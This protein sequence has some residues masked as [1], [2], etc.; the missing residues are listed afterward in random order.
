VTGA[1]DGIAA[2]STSG[3]V[4][5]VLTGGADVT[6]NSSNGILAQSAGNRTI[7]IG[8]GSVVTGVTSINTG[9]AGTTLITNAGTLNNGSGLAIFAVATTDGAVTVNN[10]AG[11]T[12]NGRVLL[13]DNADSVTNAGI[14]N[15]S[16]GNAFNGGVDAVNNQAGG[17]LNTANG[18]TF[19]GLETL[20]NAGTLNTT[21]T[22]AF[23]GVATALNNTGTINLGAASAVTGLGATTNSLR[24]NAAAGSSMAG[25]GA[26][27]NAAGGTIDTAGAFTLGGFTSFSNAGTIDLAPGAFTVPAVAFNNS[28]TIIADEGASSITGQTTFNNSGTIRMTDG[29]PDDVLT[30]NS[31]FVGSGGSNLNVDASPSAADRLVITG[32]AS[33]TTTLNV[34]VLNGVSINSSGVLVVDAGTSTA[35]AFVL[36]STTGSTLIDLS[37][38]QQGADYFLFALPNANAFDP[39]AIVN[40]GTD[41]WYQSADIYDNYAALKRSDL[42]PGAQPF[43]VWGQ[44]YYDRDRY[45]DSD[46][47]T[48]FGGDFTIN[49]RLRTSRRGIQ[50]GADYNF[51]GGVIGITGGWQ[52]VKSDLSGS[53]AEVR[54]TGWNV[55]G[56]A[57]FGSATGLYGGLLVK[58]DRNRLRLDSPAFAG[59]GRL[60]G[61]SLGAEAEGG[62]RLPV[63]SSVI[64]IG[65][66]LA[67]VTTKYKDFAFGGIGYDFD[68]AKSLRG[69][70][71]A[72]VETDTGIFVDGKVFHEFRDHNTL[73]LVSGAEIDDLEAEGRGTWFR[74]E[75]G[76]GRPHSSGPIAALW[77]ELGDVKGFGAKLGFRFGGARVAEVAPPPPPPPPP[78]PA[79][80]PATQ[81]CPDGSVILAT[82]ACPV[83]PPPPPPPAPA[84]ERGH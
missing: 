6:G 65:A 19:G 49:Q 74:G 25:T 28:G 7:N 10:L 24:I 62:Y 82:D 13:T 69:R 9:G 72:R 68:R 18:T 84:P 4:S 8:T 3:P 31:N 39:L 30:I 1:T 23:T 21:G 63:G 14:W 61:R 32:A 44:I 79:P 78:P 56:Y 54:G 42:M 22:L 20:S 29:A 17:V 15:A 43:G 48:L 2:V 40:V 47:Q 26:F 35:N 60:T 52:K 73:T 45:G 34:N 57:M 11:G 59:L 51:G 71:G 81:T 50:A 27:N 80:P 5:V 64:D 55:G 83:P 75:V 16:G 46:T 70:F 41:M 36:G 77:G 12:I 37:L 53:P 76:Y 33:G 58:D 67:W 66:G 38:E